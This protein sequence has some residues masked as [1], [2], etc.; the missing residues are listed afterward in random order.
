MAEAMAV[1]GH[2]DDPLTPGKPTANACVHRRTLPN[3]ACEP[4][5]LRG[6]AQYDATWSRNWLTIGVAQVKGTSQSG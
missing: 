3:A 2:R 5:R 6:C 4:L 1:L